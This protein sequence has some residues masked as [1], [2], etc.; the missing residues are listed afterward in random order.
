[1][2]SII[3][4]FV[5][6]TA[7]SGLLY[8]LYIG[9]FRGKASYYAQ[10]LM[11]LLIPCLAT[12]ASLLSWEVIALEGRGA[13]RIAYIQS[14]ASL[15]GAE[16]MEETEEMNEVEQAAI[17]QD[18]SGAAAERLAP[19]FDSAARIALSDYVVILWVVV[20]VALLA[21]YL[22]RLRRI[23]A[24]RS[25]AECERFSDYTIY[26]LA[27]ANMLFSFW[28]GVYLDSEI[29]SEKLDLVLR[30]ELS[31]IRKRHYIDKMIVQIYSILL[32]FNPMVRVIQREISLVQEYEADNAVL[33]SGCDARR[34]KLYIF[35][36]VT[37]QT[38]T[39]ANGLNGSQI[40]KR[41]I[42]MKRGYKVSHRVLR[43]LLTT[44]T[45]VA[46]AASSL[47]YVNAKSADRTIASI[48]PDEVKS[49]EVK[50][51][52]ITVKLK[53][54]SEVVDTAAAQ[55]SVRQKRFPYFSNQNKQSII[56]DKERKMV[57][58]TMKDSTRYEVPL[59]E[60][61]L[62]DVK[63]VGSSN[64]V[65]EVIKTD[66]ERLVNYGDGEGWL[67]KAP[68]VTATADQYL[69]A[70]KSR[71]NKEMYVVRESDRTRVFLRAIPS[72]KWHFY[73][74]ERDTELIDADSRKKYI[75]QGARGDMPLSMVVFLK[76]LKGECVY[77][78]LIF[79]PLDK[80]VEVVHFNEI[81]NPATSIGYNAS[82]DGWFFPDI[83]VTDELPYFARE[84]YKF[85]SNNNK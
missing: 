14:L 27:G 25:V 21:I 63:S 46:I 60:I 20:A 74:F 1:M 62:D 43:T 50:D 65:L 30:H 28:R 77:F 3:R 73:I 37:S 83:E 55:S 53:D 29:E 78:E 64:Y 85:E 36:E 70:D 80:G 31:H 18:V 56:I 9:L 72:W 13:E 51:G 17:T 67:E 35:E 8:L 59:D 76:D 11:L 49:V 71:E 54:G 40:K 82:L 34:Y 33:E 23:V 45:M 69:R 4:F 19:S 10:R 52:V 6:S 15:N 39:F 24:L 7:I 22:I 61:A 44:L 12:V 81:C 75:V 41:F 42:T 79:P 5:E 84:G 68:Q 57:V 58:A 66:G 47:I 26:R 32:W 2:E 38:P 48:S 16:E